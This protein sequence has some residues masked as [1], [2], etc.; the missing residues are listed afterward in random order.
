MLI[1]G[2]LQAVLSCINLLGHTVYVRGVVWLVCLCG[3]QGAASLVLQHNGGPQTGAV[4]AR[5]AVRQA[6]H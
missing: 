1:Q 3:V 5:R 4:R 6:R 2:Q